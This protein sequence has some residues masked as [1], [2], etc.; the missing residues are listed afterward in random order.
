MNAVTTAR[1]VP[2]QLQLS[3]VDADQFRKGM[4]L[5]PGAVSVIATSFA[6]QKRGLTA[7]AVSAL[8]TEPPSL[9][10][11]VNRSASAFEYFEL[12]RHF[13]VNQ[14]STKGRD[15]AKVFS[16]SVPSDRSRRFR[17]DDWQVLSTGAP[18]LKDAV[19]SFDC[20]LVE[21]KTF[22]THSILIG[23]IVSVKTNQE[24][25]PLIYLRG[26]FSGAMVLSTPTLEG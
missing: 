14:L 22:G 23:R 26:E 5:V 9:L 19:V 11:C 24:I 1:Q 8:T 10:V 18:I 13:S 4:R 6:G 17:D 15:L 20:E 12:S 21:S 7:T 3:A 16:S 2:P 25:D